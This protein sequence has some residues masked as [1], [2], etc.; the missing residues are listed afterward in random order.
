MIKKACFIFIAIFSLLIT[1]SVWADEPNIPV[2]TRSYDNAQEAF[3]SAQRAEETA[4]LSSFASD[5]AYYY[6]IALEHYQRA[7]KEAQRSREESEQLSEVEQDDREKIITEASK[8]IEICTDRYNQ[9][10]GSVTVAQLRQKASRYAI[11]G[12]KF[13]VDNDK[14]NA[15]KNWDEAIRIYEEALTHV[16]N[17]LER[18]LIQSKIKKIKFYSEKYLEK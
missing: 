8:R 2:V 17:E 4:K 9:A 15:K 5:V 14:A 1:V 10:G 18:E 3:Q 16:Q 6:H 13:A 7:L 12:F 11:E